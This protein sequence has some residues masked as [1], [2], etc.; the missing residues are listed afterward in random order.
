MNGACGFIRY[1]CGEV[2][3]ERVVLEAVFWLVVITLCYGIGFPITIGIFHASRGCI[4]DCI[5]DIAKINIGMCIA[6]LIVGFI[7]A[8]VVRCLCCRFGDVLN[9]CG[10]PYFVRL[11]RQ[12]RE[13]NSGM[14][15]IA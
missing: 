12:F 7:I 2:W 15:Q 13:R 8:G 4:R 11:Y 5:G 14:V 9:A 3:R 10:E 6:V 1:C